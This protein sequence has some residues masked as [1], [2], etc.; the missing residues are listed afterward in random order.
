[1]TTVYFREIFDQKDDDE[2]KELIARMSSRLFIRA[3]GG[4]PEVAANP[5]A[6]AYLI[7]Y[8][9][10]MKKLI[11][12]RYDIKIEPIQELDVSMMYPPTKAKH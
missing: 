11:E 5:V 3:D 12:E 8:I 2:L 4:V 7:G 10:H 6:M 9:E 1:M